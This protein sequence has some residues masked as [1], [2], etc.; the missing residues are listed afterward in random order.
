MNLKSNSGAI[1]FEKYKFAILGV[2]VVLIIGGI[3]IVQL[4]E[5]RRAETCN[6]VKESMSNVAVAQTTYFED[7]KQYAPDIETLKEKSS[8]APFM[9]IADGV[10]VK[11]TSITKTTKKTLLNKNPTEAAYTAEASH[12]VCTDES[13]DL[14]VYRFDTTKDG[15]YE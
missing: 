14:K 12:H 7:F 2:A 15:F 9:K 13:G 6:D 5:A 4:L 1:D 3:A 10:S 8:Y 11:V